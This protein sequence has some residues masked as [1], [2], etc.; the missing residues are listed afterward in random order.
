MARRRRHLTDE[1]QRLWKRVTEGAERLGP[2]APAPDAR[3]E[4]EKGQK[5]PPAGPVAAPEPA[6][7]FTPQPFRVGERARAT[8]AAAPAPPAATGPRLDRRQLQDL[9]RGRLRPE[10]RIDLH[11]LTL[12]EAEPRLGQFIRASHQRG[13][14]LVL[15]ITG[16]GRHA[17]DVGPI[18]AR[19]GVLRQQVPLWLLRPPLSHMVLEVVEAHRRHGGGGAYYVYLRKRRT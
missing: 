17:Q 15:V 13:F 3:Q 14:R 1:E 19:Q 16:K 11:G 5:N 10:A 4:D 2:R 7:R 6:R 12:A 18:P 8:E 9:R